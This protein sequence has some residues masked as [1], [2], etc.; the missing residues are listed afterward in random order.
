MGR[1][2]LDAPCSG[3]GV[4]S[5]D[6]S[7]K[8]GKDPQDIHL[9]S[10]LQ[11]ELILAAIDCLDAKSKTGGYLI[12]ST[13][14]VLPEEN[15]NVVEYVLKKRHVKLVETG[16]DFGVDGFTKYR[17]HRYHPTMNLCKRYYPHTHNMDGFFVAKIKKL[18]DQIPGEPVKK[19][20]VV[21]KKGEEQVAD[22]KKDVD[23]G[24]ESEQEIVQDKKGK[25]GG[26]KEKKQEKDTKTE[27]TPKKEKKTAKE[28]RKLKKEKKKAT[29]VLEDARPQKKKIDNEECPVLVETSPPEIETTSL[30]K[31]EVAK[32]SISPPKQ[33]PPKKSK[34]KK[35]KKTFGGKKKKKKKKKKK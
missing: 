10:H 20:V 9:C 31:S 1:V 28:E 17:E 2:L 21:A 12:Y 7:A 23:S 33:S 19:K 26:L 32:T 25:K 15:E 30:E 24:I 5:K 22:T 8:T 27:N 34:P 14:S 3:T 16:L 11:K 13:C 35:K 18:S 4:I 6:P 29:L